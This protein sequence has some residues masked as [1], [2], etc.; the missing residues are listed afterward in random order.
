MRTY[1]FANQK[2]GVGKSTVAL[3]VGAALVDRGQRV[4]LVDLDPQ[5]TATKVLGIDT[6]ELP[7][8]A[9][10]LSAGD[11]HKIG[12]VIQETSWGLDIAPAE[13]ALARREQG[14]ELGDEFLLREALEGLSGYDHVLID[15]PPSLGLLTVNALAA[16]TDIVLVTEASW[17]ALQGVADFMETY[18]VIR[19]RYNE[20]LALAGVVV[21]LVERTR[22]T[23][24]R[25]E[26]LS[27]FF[28]DGMVWQPGVPKR[29]VIREALAAGV[30]PSLQPG[31][32][33]ARDA[34]DAFAIFAERIAANG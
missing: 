11:G 29:A 7:S 34:L 21:N 15:C 20:G 23:R 2:G 30:P 32:G 6:S 16:A 18:D 14:R 24:L 22:E 13:I 9:D 28:G 33:A 25:I 10:L 1:A 27:A 8:M 26:E 19:R 3:C 31:S 4:L 12:E 17:M 5:G